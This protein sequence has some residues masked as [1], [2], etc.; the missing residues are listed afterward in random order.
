MWIPG[1]KLRLYSRWPEV[2]LRPLRFLRVSLEE[3]EVEAPQ[4]YD[5]GMEG[6]GWVAG[7]VVTGQSGPGPWGPQQLG[8]ARRVHRNAE[9]AR[10][11]AKKQ[12]HLPLLTLYMT[13]VAMCT[14]SFNLAT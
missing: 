3:E 2:R 9:T 6:G 4:S 1:S 13:V 11:P 7:G 10:L 5:A 8:T 12:K 14:T